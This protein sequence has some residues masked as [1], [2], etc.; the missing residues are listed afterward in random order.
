M[1]LASERRWFGKISVT[2]VNRFWSRQMP[3]L[4]KVSVSFVAA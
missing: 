1:Q 3:Y 4:V 2:M